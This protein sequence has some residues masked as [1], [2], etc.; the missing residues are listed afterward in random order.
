MVLW[1]TFPIEIDRK[2]QLLLDELPPLDIVDNAR[3]IKLEGNTAS[4]ES[5]KNAFRSCLQLC[6]DRINRLIETCNGV[7]D[8][9]Q[10]SATVR[11]GE[12][13]QHLLPEFANGFSR[14]YRYQRIVGQQLV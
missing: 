3:V 14:P 1:D 6:P 11:G 5:L 9:L 10:M 13:S 4:W 2:V 12:A 7:A 8:S